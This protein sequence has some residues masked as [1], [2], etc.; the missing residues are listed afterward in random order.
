MCVFAAVSHCY[1][2]GRYIAATERLVVE[3]EE[4][5]VCFPTGRFE[6]VPVCRKGDTETPT[7]TDGQ[8]GECCDSVPHCLF[9]KSIGCPRI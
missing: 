3:C 4:S 6:C 7:C 5:C 1:Y 8:T 9:S 2:N